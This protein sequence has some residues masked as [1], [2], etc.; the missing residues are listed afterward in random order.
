VNIVSGKRM[1]HVLE[2]RGWTLAR[3]KGSH[4]IYRDAA[5][6]RRVV[7]PVHGNHDLKPGTQR[8]IMRDAG[9]TDAD[10]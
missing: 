5:T 4:H 9:L 3:I 6:G 8:G 2:Q 10:L 7:V 1:C